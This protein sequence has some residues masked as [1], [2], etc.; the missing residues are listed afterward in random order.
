MSG[1]LAL[2]LR[3]PQPD[4][5]DLPFGTPLAQWPGLTTRLVEVQRG[6]SRHEVRF[7]SYGAGIFALKEL[8]VATTDREYDMLLAL[9]ERNMP[10]VVAVGHA[11]VRAAD[12]EESGILIT[13]YLDASLPYR[14]LFQQPGLMR[15]RE[16]LLDAMAGLL[17]RLHLAGF[18]WG[19]C[20]LSNTLF[21][22]D[23]GELTAYLVDAETTE[24]HETLGDGARRQDL[25]ILEENITGDLAD[26]AMIAELPGVLDV[27]ETGDHIRKRYE[28]LWNEINRTETIPVGERWRI[29]ERVRKLNALGFSVGEIELEA[30]GDGDRL[31]MRTIVTDR[32]YHRHQFHN[33]TGL[34]AGEKQAELM[35]N[36]ILE[37]RATLVRRDDRSTPFSIA[38]VHWL[39]ER[40]EP[41]MKILAPLLEQG[42]DPAELYCQVLEHKWFLSERAQGDVG[43]EP[44]AEDYVEMFRGR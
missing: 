13:R 42:A 3:L 22:R 43:F 29:Q 25:M 1:L 14:T 30:T 5:L 38:V 24:H 10:S 2:N 39:R 31:R 6:L 21:R 18:Y 40:W 33:L 8:P 28:S 36:E 44:A 27:Y 9:E 16:R 15:Y 34:I 32:D 17:V 11:R 23:A 19:D 35:L 41:A 12:G 4:F 37:L 7:V 26:L 20:S